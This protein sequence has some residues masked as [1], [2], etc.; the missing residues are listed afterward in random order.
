MPRVQRFDADLMFTDMT[1]KGWQA[2]DLAAKA[3][4]S[5]SSVTRFF[6]GSFQTTRM[7]KKLAAALGFSLRRYVHVRS[8][9]GAPA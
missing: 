6:D 3:D 4:V 2:A 1:L 8:S 5:R 9:S 7:A